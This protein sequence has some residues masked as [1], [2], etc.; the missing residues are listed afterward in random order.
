MHLERIRN[1]IVQL[2]DPSSESF[3]SGVSVDTDTEGAD[4]QVIVASAPSSQDTA[5][6]KKSFLPVTVRVQQEND[7]L[8][9]QVDILL[10]QQQEQI[11]KL[12][13]LLVEQKE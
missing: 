2:A 13:D 8:R 1:A 6:F 9:D 11:S 12:K 4:S 3:T 10:R 7:R 5:N